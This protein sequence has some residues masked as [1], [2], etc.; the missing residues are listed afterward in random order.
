MSPVCHVGPPGR[1]RYRGTSHLFPVSPSPLLI[2]TQVLPLTTPRY[3]W[4][5]RPGISLPEKVLDYDTGT[6]SRV[7]R[8]TPRRETSGCP[9]GTSPWDVPP[10]K[11][12]SPRGTISAPC[13]H[14]VL[15]SRPVQ[16]STR[17]RGEG[18]RPDLGFWEKTS[19]GRV[20]LEFTGLI[21]LFV[22]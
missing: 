19:E 8:D 3:V 22:T 14:V 15:L 13:P 4:G 10:P 2:L 18:R 7:V 11:T 9:R 5:G 20:R 16:S 21:A 6:L 17:V 1:T 12:S